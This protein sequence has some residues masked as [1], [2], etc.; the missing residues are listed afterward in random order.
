MIPLPCTHLYLFLIVTSIQAPPNAAGVYGDLPE[1][2]LTSASGCNSPRK[3]LWSGTR[4]PTPHRLH[5]QTKK[6]INWCSY[7]TGMLY[8]H[9][10]TQAWTGQAENAS[11]H[12]TLTLRLELH[13]RISELYFTF[14]RQES[15][16]AIQS[17]QPFSQFRMCF[18]V[19]YSI[20]VD[21]V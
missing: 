7:K 10:Y 21:V 6:C 12:Y 16:R 11:M 15:K 4:L 5:E 3:T 14:T 2:C 1:G 8:K 18:A 9:R 17:I 13:P 20:S 19:L